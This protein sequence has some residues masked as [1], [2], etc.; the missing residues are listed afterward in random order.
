MSFNGYGQGHLMR[1]LTA[2]E[3]DDLFKMSCSACSACSTDLSPSLPKILATPLGGPLIVLP[4]RGIN[5][6]CHTYSEDIHHISSATVVTPRQSGGYMGAF[7]P[8]KCSYC[9][10]Y[11]WS[12]AASQI[13]ASEKFGYSKTSQT[14]LVQ[15]PDKMANRKIGVRFLTL[16]YSAIIL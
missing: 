8:L 11:T 9:I 12:E 15:N 1:M 4:S 3:S 6:I 5:Q 2:K 13:V 7:P 14:P 16:I 10:S